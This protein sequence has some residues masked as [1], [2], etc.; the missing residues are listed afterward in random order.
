MG[1]KVSFKKIRLK[2]IAS[3]PM[4]IEMLSIISIM[5]IF[6]LIMVLSASSM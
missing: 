1:K 2:R 5:V 6:G 4:D 3:N